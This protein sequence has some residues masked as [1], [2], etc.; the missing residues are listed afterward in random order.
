MKLL[1]QLADFFMTPVDQVTLW[2]Q[3]LSLAL[4]DAWDSF[5]HTASVSCT[6]FCVESVAVIVICYLV[7]C[8]CRV[9]CT[10]KDETFSEYI[11]KSMIA[12]LCYFFAKCGGNIILHYMGV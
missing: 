7:Y 5:W 3:E 1:N 9:M 8:A 11:N 2:M 6:Q 10:T 4:G 12:G